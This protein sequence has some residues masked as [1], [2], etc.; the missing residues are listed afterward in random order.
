MPG[1][2]DTNYKIV[3]QSVHIF[4]KITLHSET[5]GLPT[6]KRRTHCGHDVYLSTCSQKRQTHCGND[7]YLGTCSHKDK[8]IHTTEQ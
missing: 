1:R 5:T 7:I 3:F 8:S 4:G 2:D 6:V